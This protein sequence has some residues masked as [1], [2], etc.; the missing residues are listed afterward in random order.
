[1][2]L[3]V[4]L[5]VLLSKS[6]ECCLEHPLCMGYMRVLFPVTPESRAGSPCERRGAADGC[7]TRGPQKALKR[8]LGICFLRVQGHP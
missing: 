2:S 5:S 6:L 7:V 8:A 1:M 3:R 4:D